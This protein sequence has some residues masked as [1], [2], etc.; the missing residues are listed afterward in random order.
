LKVEIKEKSS[1]LSVKQPNKVEKNFSDFF[2]VGVLMG[3]IS[4]SARQG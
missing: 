2:F 3:R 1:R 4:E